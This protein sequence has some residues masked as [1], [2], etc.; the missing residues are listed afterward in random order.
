MNVSK[1]F[2]VP[3]SVLGLSVNSAEHCETCFLILER[4]GKKAKIPSSLGD[5]VLNCMIGL[6]IT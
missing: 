5:P 2:T 4:Q 6:E 1:T 3:C